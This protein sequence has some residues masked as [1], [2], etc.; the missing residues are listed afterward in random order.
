MTEKDDQES[1]EFARE[2]TKLAEDR[3]VL[4]NERSFNSWIGTSL[5]SLGLAVG[6]QA[7]F[8]ETEPTW[9]A[10][11]TATIF[12]MI[13]ILLSIIGYRKS[14]ATDKKLKSYNASG[15]QHYQLLIISTSMC[16]GAVCIGA[17]LWT[18]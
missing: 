7:V 17:I 11:V 10:K 16:V 1:N 9:I 15:T 8:G 18:L 6:L 13:G 12:V 4:A 3:T 5:G 2:R 14:V